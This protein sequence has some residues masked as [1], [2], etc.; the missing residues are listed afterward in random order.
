M[1]LFKF[2]NSVSVFVA[3]GLLDTIGTDHNKLGSIGVQKIIYQVFWKLN[4]NISVESQFVF[5][6]DMKSALR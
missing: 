3:V 2:Y 4:L 1:F 6:D 5:L